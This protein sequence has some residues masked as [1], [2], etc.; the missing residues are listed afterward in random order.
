MLIALIATAWLGAAALC[1]VV[2]AMAAR[3]D[4]AIATCG[5]A[6]SPRHAGRDTPIGARR[7]A[8]RQDM[9]RLTVS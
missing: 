5:D 4:A 7:P 9:P 3:G 8:M 6:E 2:C 1:W